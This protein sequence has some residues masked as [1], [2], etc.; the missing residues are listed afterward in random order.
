MR[1]S[2]KAEAVNIVKQS[3]KPGRLVMLGRDH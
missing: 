2:W 1:S 3:D